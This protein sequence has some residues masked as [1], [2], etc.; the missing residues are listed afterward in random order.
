MP[1]II[2][3]VGC[4]LFKGLQLCNNML[5]NFCDPLVWNALCAERLL[6]EG[7]PV[8]TASKKDA[9]ACNTDHRRPLCSFCAAASPP[10]ANEKAL[11]QIAITQWKRG[12]SQEPVEPLQ[13]SK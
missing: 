3:K 6:E 10:P 12:L 5:F 11:Q 8:G 2:R 1:S 4:I 9:G 13:G 7:L